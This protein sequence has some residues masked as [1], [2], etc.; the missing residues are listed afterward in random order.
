[1]PADLV[2]RAY[3][4]RPLPIGHGQ[5]ISQPLIVAVMTHLLH[6][7][8]D[9]RVL[10]VGT[11]SGYQTAILAELAGEVVTIEMVEPISPQRPQAKLEALGYDNVEFRR[12][13]R[14]R[15]LPRAGAVRCASWSPPRRAPSRRALIEQLAPGGRLVIP[16]GRDPLSQDLFLVEKDAAGER[17]PAA[18]V[19]GR[20]RAADRQRGRRTM[21]AS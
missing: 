13:R 10:E 14:R 12:R 1:M 17:A 5:T 7:G 15:R 11:G 16:I 20:V 19:P 3:D 4:N 21:Q 2:A 18:P 8:A 9:A 6:L